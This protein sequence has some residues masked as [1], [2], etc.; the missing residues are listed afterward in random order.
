LKIYDLSRRIGAAIQSARP[1]L[2]ILLGALLATPAA[3]AL[4]VAFS[5]SAECNAGL[6][7]VSNGGPQPAANCFQEQIIPGPGE[8]PAM[9]AIASSS[10]NWGPQR[11]GLNA[12]AQVAAANTPG[13][14]F[15]ASASATVQLLD[16]FNVEAL[17]AGGGNVDSGTMTVQLMLNGFLQAFGDDGTA[18]L[19][20]DIRV[21]NSAPATDTISTVPQNIVPIVLPVFVDLSWARGLPILVDLT[22][23][24]SV[25]SGTTGDGG[26][27][28]LVQFGNSLD[29]AGIV[30]VL[31]DQG[32]PVTSFTALSPDGVDWA[33]PAAAVPV[34]AAVWL[35][36]SALG[37]LGW[38]RLKTT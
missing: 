24:A 9:T 3:N 31:D 8:N 11:I 17:N 6:G 35:F 23:T 36:G 18:D 38:M 14:S 26:T 29:W 25:F 32:A 33:L 15:H 21:G 27:Q 10:S 7:T 30:S 13:G 19:F 2:L 34:P 20:Y 12:Q 28:T 37:L 22:A 4:S 5:A 1:T 16:E